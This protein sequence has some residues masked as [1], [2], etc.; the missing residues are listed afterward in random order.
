MD[1]PVE[2]EAS[3]NLG[4]VWFIRKPTA[5]EKKDY[6][7]LPQNFRNREYLSRIFF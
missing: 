7:I 1:D 6:K 3:Q 5:Y 2:I 4:C